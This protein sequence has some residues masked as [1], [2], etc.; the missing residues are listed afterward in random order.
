MLQSDRLTIKAGEAVQQARDLA[1]QRGNPV[2]NDAHLFAALLDQDD[3]IVVPVLQKAGVNVTELRDAT[4]RELGRL[5]TQ[6]GGSHPQA[7]RELNASLDAADRLARSLGDAFVSTEHLLLA[8]IETK[9]T[10]AGSR[11]S[12]AGSSAAAHIRN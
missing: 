6:T 9:G 10:T 11:K 4:E 12:S 7:A 5:P 8:L 3:G 1:A 2:M